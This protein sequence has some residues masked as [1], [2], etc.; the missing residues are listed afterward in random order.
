MRPLTLALLVNLSIHLALCAAAARAAEPR[1][2]IISIDGGRPDVLLRADMP[3]LRALMRDGSFTFWALTTPASVTMPSHTSMLTGVTIERHGITGNDDKS[4]EG[5]TSTSPTLFE[6]ARAR[7]ISTAMAAGKSKFSILL[8]DVD[9]AWVNPRSTGRDADV[10]GHAIDIIRRHK[11]R[12]MFVHF[13]NNDNLGHS[14]G[15]GTPEQLKGL[16]DT[17]T[18]IG[19][20][21]AALADAG[22]RDDTTILLSSDH[23]GRGRSHG[24]DDFRSLHIPWIIT[25]PGVRR[26][27][28]LSRDKDLVI[29]TYDTFATVCQV[30]GLDVPVDSDGRPVMIAFESTELLQTSQ[31]GPPTAPAPRST[32]RPMVGDKALTTQP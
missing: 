31:A 21:L 14:V 30:L 25:G 5:Q 15:W 18:Q 13:P 32:T 16:A 20:V 9:H 12:L 11:P 17:D 23:G 7:G 29:R 4:L 10:A 2:L 19:R 1:V 24:K 6:R 8:K 27:F 22:V 26:D 28:D 3:N